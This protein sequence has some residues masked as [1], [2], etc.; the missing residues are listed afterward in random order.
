VSLLRRSKIVVGDSSVFKYGLQKLTEIP[1]AGALLLTDMPQER[2]PLFSQFIVEVTQDHMR[3][4]EALVRLVEYWLDHDEER[5]QRASL[6]Q[7][8]ALS[9]M[10]FDDDVDGLI[11]AFSDY[12]RKRFGIK[13]WH[14]IS[15]GC[16]VVGRE[17]KSSCNFE[18]SGWCQP[19]PLEPPPHR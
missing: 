15:V 10:T 9:Q 2:Q 4:E 13:L 8:L 1:G 11:H 18:R 17:P 5:K 7:Y 12:K 6:G 19:E 3:V 14:P 16:S